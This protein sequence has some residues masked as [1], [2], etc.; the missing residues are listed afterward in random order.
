MTKPTTAESL[1]SSIELY[2][3]ITSS[4]YARKLLE[5]IEYID[6]EVPKDEK[7][8]YKVSYTYSSPG[9]D[10]KS[11]VEVL[12]PNIISDI[13]LLEYM[14]IKID[15]GEYRCME[16]IEKVELIKWMT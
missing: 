13:E 6:K 2:D 9:I 16:S 7:E 1:K 3:T 12:I 11:D 15:V 5:V 14:R 8:L 10:G 4:Y